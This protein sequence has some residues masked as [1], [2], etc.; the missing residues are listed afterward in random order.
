MVELHAY[1]LN[2][3]KQYHEPHM[4]LALRDSESSGKTSKQTDHYMP[5]GTVTSGVLCGQ[6]EKGLP[7]WTDAKFTLAQV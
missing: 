5:R 3:Q 4:D 2:E 1:S 7:C 6:E